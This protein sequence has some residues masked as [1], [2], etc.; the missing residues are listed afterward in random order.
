[1]L[2]SRLQNLQLSNGEKMP[3]SLPKHLPEKPKPAQPHHAGAEKEAPRSKNVHA[4]DKGPSTTEHTTSSNG[5]RRTNGFDTFEKTN[6]AAHRSKPKN[7][8]D[9][10][11]AWSAGLNDQKERNASQRKVNGVSSAAHDSNVNHSNSGWQTTKRKNKKS[12]KAS[13]DHRHGL[14][15]GAEPL[16]ADE[17]M[18]KGG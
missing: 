9:F 13:P 16:P 14:H 15:H 17:S 6:G 12:N 10:S 18:R 7:R 2:S 3:D 8:T 1:L 11:Q 4:G 5:K